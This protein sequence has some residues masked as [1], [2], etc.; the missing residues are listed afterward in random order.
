MTA[1]HRAQV[2]A[3]VEEHLARYF[4]A[5]DRCD[6]D[7]VMTILAGATLTAGGT[8]TSDAATI[9][10]LYEA[11]QPAPTA[12]GRRRTK[13]HATN[14]VLAGPGP[15]GGWRASVYYVRL[16]PGDG[17][18]VLAASGRLEEDLLPDGD[19]WRVVRHTIVS[20]F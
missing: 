8:S 19:R 2:H 6:L 18:P 20:D 17:G 13:H 4:D 1:A 15:D 3:S 7:E 5:C 9:R 10:A 14:L 16:E 11:R 12:D